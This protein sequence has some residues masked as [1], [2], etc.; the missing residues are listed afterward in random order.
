MRNEA[1]QRQK[2]AGSIR[3]ARGRVCDGLLCGISQFDR[4][5]TTNQ[6]VVKPPAF[7]LF[8]RHLKRRRRRKPGNHPSDAAA[9]RPA[10]V[11]AA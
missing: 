3:I 11:A 8:V 2:A 1:I 5:H 6:D 4:T 7:D 10:A 9:N